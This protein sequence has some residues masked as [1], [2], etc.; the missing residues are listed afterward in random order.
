[1]IVGA[2]PAGCAAA[3]ALRR[4]GAPAHLLDRARFPRDKV[5]GDV[6]LPAALDGLRELG[7]PVEELHRLGTA[8]SGARIVFPGGRAVSGAFGG[9][10]SSWLILRRY[11]FDRWLLDRARD[12]GA[13][14]TEETEVTGVRRGAEG[15]VAGLTI[16]RARSRDEFLET[17]AVIAADGASSRM[18]GLLGSQPVRGAGL[19]VAARGYAREVRQAGP[20]RVEVH[21]AKETLPGCAWVVPADGGSWN[22]GVGYVRSA[23]GRSTPPPA[24]LLASL[25]ES[26]PDP[27]DRLNGAS[28]EEVRGWFLPLAPGRD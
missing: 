5:C 23:R 22:V 25:R 3:I 8:C 13:R 28:V 21:L 26:L 10:G 1:M 18:A 20:P 11:V 15:A 6:L 16:R 12:A 9:A 2:G 27:R 19:G 14:V 17:H 7:L 4:R 24:A